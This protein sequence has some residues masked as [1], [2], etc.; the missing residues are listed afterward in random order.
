[1]LCTARL[2]LRPWLPTDAPALLTLMREDHARFHRDF[3]KTLASVQDE[4]SARRFIIQKQEWAQR[5]CFQFGLWLPGAD[6][7][8]GWLSLKSIEWDVP[9]AEVAY[10]VASWAE[11]QG[12]MTEALA[13]VVE[14]AFVE[15]GMARLYCRLNPANGRSAR[16][17][18]RS[19]FQFEGLL[20]QNFRAGTGELTDSRV[21]GL[22]ATDFV[23]PTKET[24]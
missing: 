14:W 13:A 20:R 21:Y 8:A 6:R 5:Q 18:E 22:L 16:L 3:P 19:G 2:L 24:T 9:K 10:L 15:Q 17:A 11:G 23:A 4:A 1:M 7:C 12:L